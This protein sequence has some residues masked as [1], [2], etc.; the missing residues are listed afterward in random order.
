[1]QLTRA[2]RRI[3]G[4]YQP[5]HRWY[6]V[7]GGLAVIVGVLPIPSHPAITAGH[8]P[9]A[10]RTEMLAALVGVLDTFTVPTVRTGV[11]REHGN[12]RFALGAA[13]AASRASAASTGRHWAP[14]RWRWRPVRRGRG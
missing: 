13:G 4:A 12:I 1:M 11:A 6:R 7:G 2:A 5:N 8:Y 3:A 14:T 10:L 9:I